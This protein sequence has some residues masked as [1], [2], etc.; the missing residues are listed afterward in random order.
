[1]G[2]LACGLLQPLRF[3]RRRRRRVERVLVIKFWGI[4]S[5]SLLTPAVGS[6]R[7]RHPGARIELLTL[8]P[9]VEFARGLELFDAIR[10]LDVA[11][12]SWP[13]LFGRIVR[14]ILG[15]RH[16]RFD[17]VYDFEFFTRFSAIISL[18]TGAP[19]TAGFFAPSVWRGGFHTERVPFNRYWHVARN[20]RSL[21]GGESGEAV[22]P[23]DLVP[24]R[25]RPEHDAEVDAL[26]AADD[27]RPLVVLNPNA[28]HLSL[29]RRWP[30]ERFAALAAC[31]H[32]GDDARVVLI[33]APS[34][35]EWTG[36]VAALAP[37][38]PDDAL[39]DLSGRLSIGGLHALLAR[40][41][42]FVGNDSGPM[43]L[44]AAL[45]VPTIGLF[46]PETPQMYAPIGVRTLAL[47][48][49]PP[50]SP[51]IN[52]HNNKVSSCVLGAP[53]CLINLEVGRVHA[54]V[55]SLLHG[56]PLR[57]V[58]RPEPAAAEELQA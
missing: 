42:V 57:L 19:Q 35:R 58:E 7:R 29:E 55:R 12:A 23:E 6:L 26:L 22:A 39:L 50:C 24:F 48:E 49:P 43:H 25:V 17:A 28:G 51:C 47:Y 56:E 33:G 31:L 44:A 20:F 11:G 5:L 21:A 34:E 13:R 37:A 32:R 10:E 9:N 36:A 15:L 18:L 41:G 4:G 3:L 54:A 40:A 53:Q 38:V 46:G 30:R 16:L 14:L 8:A 45:G 2:R 27:P 1:L 52:V